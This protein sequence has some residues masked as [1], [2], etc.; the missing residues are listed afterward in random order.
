MKRPRDGGDND[1]MGVMY[2]AAQLNVAMPNS[3]GVK[4]R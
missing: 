1:G 2:V 3:I 4:R